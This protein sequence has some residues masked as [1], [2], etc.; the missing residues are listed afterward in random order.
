LASGFAALVKNDTQNAKSKFRDCDE[1]GKFAPLAAYGLGLAFEQGG[2]RAAAMEAYERALTLR[3]DWDAAQ[4]NL[5]N[6]KASI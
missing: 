5:T 1:Q 3:P 4:E 2:D 6:L